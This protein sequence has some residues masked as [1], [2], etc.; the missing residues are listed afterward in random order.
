MSI[1]LVT[2][3]YHFK[4]I[5]LFSLKRSNMIPYIIFISKHHMHAWKKQ[6][7]ILYFFHS[8]SFVY[9]ICLDISLSDQTS[10]SAS[11][12]SWT[13][14]IIIIFLCTVAVHNI[15]IHISRSYL[16]F[17]QNVHVNNFNLSL[18]PFLSLII[19]SLLFMQ[20][21]KTR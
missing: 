12:S 4:P 5:Y 21:Y 19:V 20:Y 14:H 3:S 7:Q 18:L 13:Y 15:I 1:I 11:S 16:H 2:Y 17:S 6:K 10:S 8:I 9:Y